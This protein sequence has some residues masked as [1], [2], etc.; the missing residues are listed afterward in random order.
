MAMTFHEALGPLGHPVVTEEEE[1]LSLCRLAVAG[2]MKATASLLRL[3][4]PAVARTVRLVLGP[5]R[6]EQEDVVQQSLLAFV[7]AL[8]GFRGD[9][10]PAGFA[11]R[12]AVN[13]ALSARRR[14]SERRL[15]FVDPMELTDHAPLWR[16]DAT[17]D[18]LATY[19]WRFLHDLLVRLPAEQAEVISLHIIVGHSLP[20]VAAATAT[21]LNTVKSRLRLAKEALRRHLEGDHVRG[22]GRA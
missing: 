3:V 21:P 11:S 10:H 17:D 16:G 4:A 14:Q 2:D 15:S 8:P 22:E 18:E 6:P 9:C 19:R 20:E 13:L 5:T 7:Q 12:I 1:A